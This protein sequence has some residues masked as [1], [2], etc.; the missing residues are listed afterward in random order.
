MRRR[1]E[2][3]CRCG[4]PCRVPIRPVGAGARPVE[5][6]AYSIATTGV[7]ETRLNRSRMP[8]SLAPMQPITAPAGSSCATPPKSMVIVDRIPGVVLRLLCLRHLPMLLAGNEATIRKLLRA[9]R[10]RV[11]LP[12][13]TIEI[14][15]RVEVAP[16]AGLTSPDIPKEPSF[17]RRIEVRGPGGLCLSRRNRLTFTNFTIDGNRARTCASYRHRALRSRPSPVFIH[18]NGILA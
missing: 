16:M 11:V 9:S 8:E 5:S 10:E 3:C 1:A 13:G 7:G 4:A 17:E 6:S 18:R 2:W 12:A 15:A 14:S